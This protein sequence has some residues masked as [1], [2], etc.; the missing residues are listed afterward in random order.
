MTTIVALCPYCRRGGVRAPEHK[1]GS[2]T[3]CS[4]C[5]SQFTIVPKEQA[6]DLRPGREVDADTKPSM[7]T[8]AMEPSPVVSEAVEPR[9]PREVA[10][11]ISLLAAT[12][13]GLGVLATLFP[14]GRFIG[15]GLC[16]LGLLLAVVALLGEGLARK[17]GATAAAFNL[18]AV[19]LLALAPDWLGFTPTFD[20]HQGG[21]P[22]G[23]HSISLASNDIATTDRTDASKAIHANGDVRV[24]VRVM[25]QPLEMIGPKGETR[26][27]RENVLVLH[28]G[29]T[30]AGVERRIPLS[31][32][33]AGNTDTVQLTE[34]TGAAIKVKP[35]DAGWRPA[36]YEKSE[37]VFPGKTA[38]VILAFEPPATT[39]TKR[40]DHL[41]LDL[42]GSALGL[43]DPIRFH[44]PGPF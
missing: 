18:L 36:G 22:K 23:P 5:G 25:I 37:G 2:I 38:E 14:F 34:P 43:V 40:I 33:A 39:K 44:I 6:E 26:R 15:L 35:L 32:W 28:I 27:T 9:E 3:T 41:N 11:S 4:K 12:F 42:P 8:V 16:G 29:I 21:L 24:G 20:D 10:F 19:V 31:A 7:A 1:I 13:F 30:N 17:I